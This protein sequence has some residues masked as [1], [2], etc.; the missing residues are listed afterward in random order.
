MPPP[1]P[2]G[3]QPMMGGYAANP[4]TD[5]QATIALILG[6]VGLCCSILGPVAFF[7]GQSSRNRI[8]G[9]GGTL[10][11]Y[12]QA[13]AG[14]VLGIIDTIFLALGILYVIVVF[15]IGAANSGTSGG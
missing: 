6:I 3:G 10:G 14:W 1:P 12:G 5:G 2:P 13:T 11:G 8:Q 4:P 7:L 15:V 9:S